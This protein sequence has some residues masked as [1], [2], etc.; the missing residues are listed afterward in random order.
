MLE[1]KG[2][3]LVVYTASRGHRAGFVLIDNEGGEGEGVI[4]SRRT[5]ARVHRHCLALVPRREEIIKGREIRERDRGRGKERRAKRGLVDLIEEPLSCSFQLLL[6]LARLNSI[7]SFLS[8]Y[9]YSRIP[10]VHG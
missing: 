3:A 10:H 6:F 9:V 5:A 4:K 7:I 1:M 8:F 2:D